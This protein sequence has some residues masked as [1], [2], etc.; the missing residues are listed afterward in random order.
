MLMLDFDQATEIEVKHK[1]GCSQAAVEHK[2][3]IRYISNARDFDYMTN[4][5]DFNYITD[6]G[7][8]LY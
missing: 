7:A 6:A 2:Y 5:R 8:G 3:E 4:V 1:S